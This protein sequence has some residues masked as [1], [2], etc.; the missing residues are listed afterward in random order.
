MQIL[1]G[2]QQPLLFCAALML[3]LAR[4]VCL[5]TCVVKSEMPCTLSHRHWTASL[6]IVETPWTQVCLVQR[7]GPR[8]SKA[9]PEPPLQRLVYPSIL[10][11]V[12]WQ[13]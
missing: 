1:L 2:P 13:T 7:F 10:K 12:A 5:H 8:R 11:D 4:G 6:R 9:D 3:T